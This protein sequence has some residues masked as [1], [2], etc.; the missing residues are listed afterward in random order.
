VVFILF[1]RIG[2]GLRNPARDT[3]ISH[4]AHQVGTGI[5]FGIL[6]AMDQVGAVLGPLM[7]AGLFLILDS[8]KSSLKDYQLGYAYLWLPFVILMLCLVF[9]RKKARDSGALEARSS[10]PKGDKLTKVFWLYTA[11]SFMTTTGFASFA[12][13][14]YHLKARGVLNDSQIPLL[15]AG[16]MITDAVAALII[17]KIYDEIKKRG[18]NGSRGLITLIVIPVLTFFVAPLVFSL[19][20]GLV[21]TGAL[22]WGVVMGCHE[23]IMRSAIADITPLAKRGTG[24]GMLNLA[25]G[26]AFFT[27]GAL[28]GVFYAKA[29]G[30]VI[31]AAMAAQIL[32]LPL[33]FAMRKEA[34]TE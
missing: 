29:I 31:A 9:A 17:G 15:Y 18:K 34:L 27:G 14:G 13:V 11:F 5:G 28:M 32:S 33:F 26:A 4:A 8:G 16:A 10:G 7:F 23:T 3:I 12:L 30:F 6:E 19:S 2:K 21:I 24:Y 22:I 1:E 25:Y 20:A